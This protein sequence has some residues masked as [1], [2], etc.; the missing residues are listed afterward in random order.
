VIKLHGYWRSSAAY[1]ARIG[2]ALKGLQYEYAPVNLL[3]G[4]QHSAAFLAIQPQGLAPALEVDGDAIPQSLAILEWLDETHPEPPILPKA[5][6][7]RAIVRA[8]AYVV[9]CDTHP[10]NNLRVLKYLRSDLHADE[11]AVAAY[12]AHWM[13][14][15]F[16]ALEQMVGAHGG[17]WCFGDSPTLADICLVPQILNA[18]RVKLDM[19]VYP[20]LSAINTRA[21]A[22]PAF[23]AAAPENQPD[24]VKR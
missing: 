18:G 2:L 11:A 12:Q 9:A 17:A 19:S 3:T 14:L 20:R 4:E 8:M 15:G 23:I 7:D 24:A 13:T 1:R 21:L 22:H 16:Q 5:A 6:T 10:I